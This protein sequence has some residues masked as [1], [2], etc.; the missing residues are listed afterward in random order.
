MAGAI[1]CACWGSLCFPLFGAALR[2]GLPFCFEFYELVL[3][4]LV[5]PNLAWRVRSQQG[6]A[7][8]KP[9]SFLEFAVLGVES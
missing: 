5:A 2:V 7:V 6:G 3:V 9:R 8:V 4:V 1:V